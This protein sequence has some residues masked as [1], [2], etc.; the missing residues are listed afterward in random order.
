M[1]DGKLDGKQVM[2]AEIIRAVHTGYTKTTREA[3]PFVG[4]GE[5]RERHSGKIP[6]KT[7]DHDIR[8][9]AVVFSEK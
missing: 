1:N 2:P 9:L 5:Y 6:G 8:S 7:L 4:D 3:P